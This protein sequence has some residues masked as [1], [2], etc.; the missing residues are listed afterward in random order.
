M[1]VGRGGLA[2]A[3]Y[4]YQVV[5]PETI[6]R[7]TTK[8]DS[9]GCSYIFVHIHAY[10]CILLH[11]VIINEKEAINLKLGGHGKDW[12]EDAQERLE[13]GKGREEVM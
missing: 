13:K 3:A 7:Q 8:V 4:P 5:I 6:Y 11:T 12:R 9:S 2:R 1:T 10:M